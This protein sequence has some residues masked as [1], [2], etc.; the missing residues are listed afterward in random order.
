MISFRVCGFFSFVFLSFVSLFPADTMC[1]FELGSLNLN[2]AREAVK[3]ASLFSLSQ[4]KKL[5]VL[6]I[7]ETHSTPELEADWKKEWGGQV[8]LSHG[9][10]TSSGVGVLFSRGFLPVSSSSEEVIPGRLLK[11]SAVFEDVPMVFINV[12]APT[13]GRQRV[14]F[15]SVLSDVLSSF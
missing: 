11:V 10:S 6:F 2:G 14:E 8:H 12:Y 5:D 3:R 9:S 13:V 4:A 1:E 7:Q 15:F